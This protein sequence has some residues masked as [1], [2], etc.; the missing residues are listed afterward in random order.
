M[1]PRK[2][3]NNITV[4]ALVFLLTISFYTSTASNA[5]PQQTTQVLNAQPLDLPPGEINMT[6]TSGVTMDLT[7]G[8]T[9]LMRTGIKM[10]FTP[11]NP[12]YPFIEACFYGMID[13]FPWPVQLVPCSWWELLD[14]SGIPTG[15]E[16]HVDYVDQA[17][18]HVDIC[19]PPQFPIAGWPLPLTAELKILFIEPCTTLTVS[20][21]GTT[22]EP[23][24][25]WEITYPGLEGYEFH[26]DS[27]DPQTGTFHID[28]VTPGSIEFPWPPPYELTAEK[29]ITN[30]AQCTE[31]VYVSPSGYQPAPCDWW[32]ITSPPELRGTEIHI[33]SVSGGRIHIDDVVPAPILDI[34]AYKLTV[35]KKIPTINLCDWF[36]VLRPSPWAPDINT[37]W[38]IIAPAPWIGVTFHVDQNTSTTFHVD[39]INGQLS[40]IVPPPYKV[41]AEPYN[42]TPIHDVAVTAVSPLLASVI[43]GCPDIIDVTVENQGDFAE[44]FTVSVTYGTNPVSTSPITVSSLAAHSSQIVRFW[45]IT[46]GVPTAVYT[47]TA[48][49]S[50]V[51][52]ETDTADNTLMDGQISVKLEAPPQLY[53]KKGYADYAP[54][55]IPDF[56]ERQDA[57]MNPP[58]TWTWCAPVAVANSLWWLDSE[59]ESA[60][61]PVSPPAISDSF[62]LISA[63]VLGIDDHDPA[64]VQPFIQHLAYLMDTDGMRTGILHTGT[65]TIDLEAGLAQYLSWTGVNP[66]GDVNADGIV[67]MI[68]VTIISNAFGSSPGMANWNMAADIF[69]I[70]T[71]WPGAADNIIDA[72]DLALVNANLGQRGMFEKHKQIQPSLEYVETELM[73][74]QD[75]VLQLGYWIYNPLSPDPW[76]RES[77]HFVTVAG[78]NASLSKIAI[79]DPIHDAFENGLILEGRIP[80]P[81]VHVLPEPPYV[82][83]N[84]AAYVSHDIYDVAVV[85]TPWPCPGG[86]LFLVNF[87]GWSPSPPYFTVVEA[88]IVTSPLG[89]HD[90]AVTNLQRLKTIVGQGY[91][92]KLNVTVQN[93]GDFTET[94]DVTAY[95]S[96]MLPPAATCRT[97][98]VNLLKGE[99][100]TVTMIW[101]TT[102]WAYGNYTMS[103]VAD[104]V[105]G[106]T[107]TVDNTFFDSWVKVTIPGDTNGDQVVNVLDLILI[108]THLGHINGDG[109]TPF[110]L[111]WYKCMNTDVQGDNVH[112]VLDLILCASHLGQHWP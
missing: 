48:T 30:I 106:E 97:T 68:D 1:K 21:I 93:Q 56:D 103:A 14:P 75:V 85:T 51:P 66:L 63:Y 44:T 59:F 33:D 46:T 84:D 25:W 98:I 110:T 32:E 41:V 88:A 39:Q 22:P 102:L 64:N 31:L 8:T 107:D 94:F 35:E 5:A 11:Q 54:S 83:H 87:P 109:H 70:T 12:Q 100:R 2:T 3:V 18:F 23:C 34:T 13:G 76:Y 82:T 28:Q 65:N 105:L 78:V 49:A 45:W 77:G 61:P 58:G 36:P 57:W 50:I 6:F 55:G 37:W 4:L 7:T 91:S 112:N 69:P 79:S 95:A 10:Q 38:R 47:I 108:A 27:S 15:V 52:G 26:V 62:R 74:C 19:I 24:S 89:V 9:I 16:F 17:M 53:W 92:C 86:S 73:K 20:D 99:I 40:V 80:I 43:L 60:S 101:D 96:A 29:K 111:D 81:H 90:V 67:D 104:T 42:P 72:N 71:T